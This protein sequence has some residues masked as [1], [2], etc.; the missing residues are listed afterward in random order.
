MLF[1]PGWLIH[2]VTRNDTEASPE[3]FFQKLER[4]HA[5]SRSLVEANL[6]Q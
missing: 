1:L 5:L 6:K 2:I 4:V 3:A